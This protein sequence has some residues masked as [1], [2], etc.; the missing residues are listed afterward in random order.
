MSY[1]DIQFFFYLFR[2]VFW[3][4]YKQQELFIIGNL[5]TSRKKKL[6]KKKI[7]NMY[8]SFSVNIG[9]ELDICESMVK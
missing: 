5:L 9:Y 7:L 4:V 2:E 3:K 6:I 1:V 8:G